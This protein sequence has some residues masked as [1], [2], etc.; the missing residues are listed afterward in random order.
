MVFERATSIIARGGTTIGKTE[1]LPL[2]AR[3]IMDT[4]D[5]EYRFENPDRGKRPV[6]VP[7][8]LRRKLTPTLL[9]VLPQTKQ[10]SWP[11]SIAR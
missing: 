11:F 3:T 10:L 8:E 5:F 7:A 9:K 6:A 4:H 2:S 1:I